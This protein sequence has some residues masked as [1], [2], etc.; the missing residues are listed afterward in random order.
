MQINHLKKNLKFENDNSKKI[1]SLTAVLL[2]SLVFKEY[3]DNF[4]S[5]L[6]ELKKTLSDFFDE[7]GF[8]KNRNASDLVKFSK[9]LIL[10]KECMKD[11][12]QY[13]PEF[14]DEII[15]K[16]LNCLSSLK[17]PTNQIPLFNGA[18]E[19]S[20]EKYLNYIERLNYSF[21]KNKNLIGKIKILKNR[22]M[23]VFFDVGP[24]PKKN[25]T[26]SYQLGPLSFEYFL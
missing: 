7:D 14:L 21:K 19:T 3:L 13:I 4:E 8:P 18:V 2:S 26:G 1:E 17:T 10:I 12:Q 5:S 23:S 9:Y 15:E 22:K 6:K 16:N 25:F 11:A 20:I 24:P